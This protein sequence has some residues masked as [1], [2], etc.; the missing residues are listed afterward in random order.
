MDAVRGLVRVDDKSVQVYVYATAIIS[1]NCFKHN[2][3][4]P[5]RL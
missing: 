2:F 4:V 3:M 5:I 1:R